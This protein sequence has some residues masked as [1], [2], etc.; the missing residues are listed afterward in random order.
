MRCP[1]IPRVIHDTLAIL[2]V[3]RV[4][5]IVMAAVVGAVAL[6]AVRILSP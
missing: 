4:A 3:A 1:Q 2:I 6:P 5:A